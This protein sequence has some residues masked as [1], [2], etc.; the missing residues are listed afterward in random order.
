M[1]DLR[2]FMRKVRLTEGLGITAPWR[3]SL[4]FKAVFSDAT[5]I[6]GF[7]VGLTVQTLW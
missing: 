4:T 2:G 3:T 6:V 5:Q 7:L 1:P